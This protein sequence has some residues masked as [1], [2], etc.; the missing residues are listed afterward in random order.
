[1]KILFIAPRYSGGIGGHAFRIAQKLKESGFDVELM[2]VPHIPIK[3]LKNPSFTIFGIIKALLKTESYDIVHAFNVPSAFIMKYIKAKKK[4]LSVHGVYSEQIGFIHS[5]SITSIVSSR[6]KQVLEWADILTTDSQKV[7]NDYKEKSNL[8][9]IHIPAPL[10]FQKLQKIPDTQ[11]LKNQVIYLGRDSFEKG[12]DI[13][14]LIENKIHGQV[15]YCTNTPWDEA[16][17]ELKRSSVLVIP[18]RIESIPQT[19]K[20]AYYLKTP[21][22]A[23]KVGGVPEIVNHNKTGIIIPSE[24]P[25]AL[26]EAINSLLINDSKIKTLTENAFDF[27]T[28]NYSWDVLLPKYI[29]FYNDIFKME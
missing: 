21:V 25:F 5:K 26:V 15:I 28:K 18:S 27:V 10:D 29:S 2:H 13:L 6:E 3:N 7:K 19:I 4:I 20:E 16:M 14:K 24:D 23:T 12:I 9:V 8:E 1:M 22:I 17:I 11:Q